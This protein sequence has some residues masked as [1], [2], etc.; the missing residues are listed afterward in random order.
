MCPRI[1]V[2]G[3]VCRAER[4][5]ERERKRERER[6]REGGGEGGAGEKK[7]ERKKTVLKHENFSKLISI[8]QRVITVLF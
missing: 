5:K 6:E 3:F 7:K 8:G 4:E 1:P 2:R